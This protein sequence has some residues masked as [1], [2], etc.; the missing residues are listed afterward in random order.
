MIKKQVIKLA[1]RGLKALPGIPDFVDFE[2]PDDL[3]FKKFTTVWAVV[4]K[5]GVAMNSEGL[6]EPRIFLKVLG[7]DTEGK[8]V[9]QNLSF[10]PYELAMVAN[11]LNTIAVS[12]IKDP[13]QVSDLKEAMEKSASK[14]STKNYRGYL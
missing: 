10:D 13:D 3:D 8:D 9:D 2:M 11:V 6:V 4:P 7:T 1:R 14:N 12:L 5:A